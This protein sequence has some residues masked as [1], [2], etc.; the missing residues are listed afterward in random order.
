V[1]SWYWESRSG[2]FRNGSR[3]DCVIS[4]HVPFDDTANRVAVSSQQDAIDIFFLSDRG[5]SG[6][7]EFLGLLRLEKRLRRFER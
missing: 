2:Q 1:R 6:R 7:G 4:V 3:F 5:L